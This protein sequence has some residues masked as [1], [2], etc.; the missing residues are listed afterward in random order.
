MTPAV[1]DRTR[2]GPLA[3]LVAA[4]V[5]QLVVLYA[6]SA[7]STG[8]APLVDKGV[9]LLVFLVPTVLAL[10][11]GLPPRRVVALLATH[12][13]LSEVVQGAVL[14][15][16]SGDPLDA[17]ADLVGVGLGAMLVLARRRS[18]GARPRW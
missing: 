18:G 7:P 4:V 5:V 11:V 14:P 15:H 2:R 13:V 12:A 8:G 16:R 6:P 3:A 17:V 1:P 10:R 9:H